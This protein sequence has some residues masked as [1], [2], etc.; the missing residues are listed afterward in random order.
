[1]C[2]LCAW[3]EPFSALAALHLQ[4]AHVNLTAIIHDEIESLTLPGFVKSAIEKIV[5]NLM[6][7][8]DKVR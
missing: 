7:D 5:G 4:A 8:P 2:P 6:D 3:F 1:M